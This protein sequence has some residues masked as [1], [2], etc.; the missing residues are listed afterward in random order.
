MLDEVR[1]T[2][3][4]AAIGAST[5]AAFRS[6]QVPRLTPPTA[7]PVEVRPFAEAFPEL[8]IR[9]LYDPVTFPPADATRLR[10]IDLSTRALRA[11]QRL[12]P[13][14]TPPV[15][16]DQA[17]LMEA[18]YPRAFRRVRPDAPVVPDG[19]VAPPGEPE[20]DVLATLSVIGPFA[21]YLRSSPEDGDD[22]YQLDVSWLTDYPTHADLEPPGGT[23]ILRADTGALRTAEYRG[24]AAGAGSSQ[25]RGRPLQR[26]ALLA[27]LN[28]DL[29]TFRHNVG[30]HLAMLTPFA[31]ASA[32]HLGVDHPVRRLLHHCFTTVLIGNRELATLQL[33]GAHGFSVH[34]FSHDPA[35]VASMAT[36][37][38]TRYD[39]WDFEPDQQ[40]RRRGTTTTPFDY[41][42]RDNVLELWAATL[43]YVDRYLRLYYA[44]DG[45]VQGDEQ[46][47]A[48]V[49]ELDS[50]VPQGISRPDQVRGVDWLA[51]LCAT[52]IHVST[53]EHDA[54]NN[55]V[56]DFSTP[57]WLIPTVV[58]RSGERMDQRRAF[59]LIATLIGTWKPYAM[60]LTADVPS[61]A[62]DERGRNVMSQWI[63]DL[64]EIQ[65]RMEARGMDRRLVYPANL[66]VSISN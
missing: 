25:W 49:E 65:Q 37:Y 42:Y 15:P 2:A 21:S 31:V 41:P 22:A 30:V 18:V 24:V 51:R 63:A 9:G 43:G 5:A 29:T 20:P 62:V 26:D 56:W 45:D 33:G 66:N 48:W 32:N 52:V 50:F 12:A 54:L 47:S 44:S 27:G 10:R 13:A 14:R 6:Q 40:F 16:R 28:E 39:F 34:I 4:R 35:T 46:L 57:S 64:A 19:L 3:Y 61:L 23:A 1:F 11:V 53:T 7:G 55:L 59:D 58:P 38:V 60:L 17:A 36:D 8:P